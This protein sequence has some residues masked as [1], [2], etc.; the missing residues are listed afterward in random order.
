[1]LS[2]LNLLSNVQACI[3]PIPADQG[4]KV[5]SFLPVCHVYERML[6]YLYMYLGCSIYFA[7]SMETIGENIREVK[8]EVF[9][10]VPRLIEKVFDKIMLKGEDLTGIKRKLFFW[11]VDLAEEY[12]FMGKSVWYTFKLTIA[13]KLIFKKWQEALGGNVRAI[14]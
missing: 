14:A 2:H 1:M 3:A 10:A 9:S 12:D 7:E 5:L 8:P 6:H 4:S 13:R 11:A